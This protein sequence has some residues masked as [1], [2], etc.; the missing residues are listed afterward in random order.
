ML[1]AIHE[2]NALL[3]DFV[4]KLCLNSGGK[5]I[6]ARVFESRPFFER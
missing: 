6:S 2:H 1:A 3:F 5:R 4:L